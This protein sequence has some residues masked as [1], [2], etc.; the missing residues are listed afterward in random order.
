MLDVSQSN[1]QEQSD[2]EI[3]YG[4]EEIQQEAVDDEVEDGASSGRGPSALIRAMA[5]VTETLTY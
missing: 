3:N 1:L 4:E 2:N 5:K